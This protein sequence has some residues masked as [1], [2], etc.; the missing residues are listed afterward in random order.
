MRRIQGK[1]RNDDQYAV[2]IDTGDI[3]CIKDE[4]YYEPDHPI[5]EDGRCIMTDIILKSGRTISLHGVT[6]DDVML[7]LNGMK[8]NA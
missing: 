6:A 3:S 1:W 5:A 8:G 4:I 2:W 7:I